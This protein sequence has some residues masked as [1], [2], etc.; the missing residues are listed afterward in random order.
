MSHTD[1]RNVLLVQLP[2]PPLGPAPIR[3]NV[4]LAARLPQAV[5]RAEGTRRLLRHRHLPRRAGQHAG[6]PRPGR[7]PRRARALA[8]RLHLL[9]LEHR[10]HALDRP[11]AEAAAARRPHR[12]GRPG[13]HGRQRLGA[14]HARLRFRRHRRGRADLRQPAARPARRRRAARAHRRAVRPAAGAG[15]RYRPGPPARP[16]ARR[17]RTST[18]SARP[19]SPAS[20]TRPTSKCCCWKRR[21][22]ASSS[23][24]S[25]TTRRATTSSITSPPRPILASLRH[26]AERG[27]REVFLLDPTLNQRKDFADFLRLLAEGNPG[28]RFTY[29]G[30]LRGE[31]ITEETARLLREANF[32]E[33]EVGL[34]SIEPD[35][36]TLMDRK[37]NLRAFERGVR[38]MLARASASRWT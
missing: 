38:A 24:S 16:S 14:G 37:N 22:A 28:R 15:P 9:P 1:R 18:S 13:D 30:E 5:R 12:P 26:A 21:A 33:V 32:T 31:G 29:F 27:A 17:C 11:R 35:A 20:S 8:G 23:A 36:M 19:T 3:G 10:A 6:R 4:P 25:A 34:Q 7:R 2:I